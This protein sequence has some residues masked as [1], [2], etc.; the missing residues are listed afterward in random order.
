MMDLV[1]NLPRLAWDEATV[2]RGHAP[3]GPES[4]DA[5][6]LNHVVSAFGWA[7]APQYVSAMVAYHAVAG[8]AWACPGAPRAR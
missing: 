4:R 6:D 7:P 3:I 1:Y 2:D 8:A 5:C